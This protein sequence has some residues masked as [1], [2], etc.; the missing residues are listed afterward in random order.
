M[1]EAR[2]LLPPPCSLQD[3]YIHSLSETIELLVTED[4]KKFQLFERRF[5]SRVSEES[6]TA[7]QQ[8]V[9]AEM[10]LQ[11]SFVYLKF[12]NEMDA[13]FN[14]RSAYNLARNCRKKNPGFIP[15]RKTTGMLDIMIGAVPEKYGWIL[16]LL[17]LEGNIG[18]GLKDLTLV[19]SSGTDLASEA[20]VLHA[21]INTFVLQK[22][23]EG[24]KEIKNSVAIHRDRKLVLFLAAAIAMKNSESGYALSLLENA[25]FTLSP[26]MKENNELSIPYAQYLR[27]EA[28][29]HKG[30]YQRAIDAYSSFISNY[31][32]IN[33]LK[34]SY[35]KTGLCYWLVGDR[36]K[37]RSYFDEARSRGKE[38]TEADK[39]AARTLMSGEEPNIPLS[40]VRHFTDGGFYIQADSTIRAIAPAMLRSKKEQVEYYYRKARLAHKL[41][42][43]EA[44]KLFYAQT[45]DMSESDNW[46]F[47]PNS[48]LQL[49]YIAVENGDIPTARKWFLKALGYKKHEYK[50]SIDAKAKSALSQLKA[51]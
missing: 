17:G 39:H 8:F 3:I 7:M 9:E 28:Y 13:A 32:G 44:A 34:D 49:G 47:A 45:I 43:H 18:K 29:L 50:N 6:K 31:A 24:T 46:Y 33:Y 27:G 19:A 25:N 12:G 15:V 36:M 35:F 23:A 40:Q 41:G 16:S 51:R 11:W 22:P 42:Q 4:P 10:R 38:S 1:D 26:E 48:S 20:A 37:A 5:E 14:L 30:A 2:R 21:V